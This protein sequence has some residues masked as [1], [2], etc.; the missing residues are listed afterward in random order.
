MADT[1]NDCRKIM[2]NTALSPQ[3]PDDD[4]ETDASSEAAEDGAKAEPNTN[5]SSLTNVSSVSLQE[6]ANT[7]RGSVLSS[8]PNASL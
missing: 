6:A 7:S 8:A 4:D 1:L 2:I 5:S 3:A